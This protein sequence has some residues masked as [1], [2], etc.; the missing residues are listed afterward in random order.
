M[1]VGG[2]KCVRFFNAYL[3]AVSSKIK[4]ICRYK[5]K[6]SNTKGVEINIKVQKR[7]RE[8]QTLTILYAGVL[9]ELCLSA[10]SLSR[11]LTAESLKD[12]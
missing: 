5:S 7:G 3:N 10:S 8:E 9:A 4:G 2:T 6:L 11:C 12:R 1:S